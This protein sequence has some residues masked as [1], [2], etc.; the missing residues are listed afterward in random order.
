MAIVFDEKNNK[1]QGIGLYDPD[2]PIR[3]KMLSI[4]NGTKIDKSWLS[5][6]IAIAYAKRQQLL[7]SDVN[8]YRLL[9]G[10]N[11]GFPSLICDVYAQIAVIKIYSR[12]WLPFLEDIKEA[13]V[14]TTECKTMVLRL[15][16]NVQKLSLPEGIEEGAIIYG[17]LSTPE[18]IFTE[19]DVQ[20]SVNVIKGHKTGFFLD[21]RDNRHQI[22]KMAKGKKVLDVFSYAG[23][24]AIHAL[25]GGATNV[26][27]V[28][29][30]KHA[31]SVAQDNAKLN[32][33]T[34]ETINGDA[35]AILT[36]MVAQNERFDIII[37]DPPAFAKAQSE[38]EKALHHY[39]RLATL[40]IKLIKKD[41]TLLLASC[42][43]RITTDDFF[44]TVGAGMDSTGM[45]YEQ[46]RKAFHDI[47]HPIS[48]SEG[49]YLKCGYYKRL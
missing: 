21:H 27:A 39:R 43:S 4:E 32:G 11:D 12:I 46:T 48:F 49:A 34:L 13:I 10:E 16:R 22:Q 20:F 19:Y 17:T 18:I 40:G 38:I 14:A 1:F 5:E 25:K 33:V 9:F 8:G 24:F 37:I 29:I 42:S 44:E 26:T 41:G 47:D 3:I 30:S 2:S 36:K 7:E 15:S 35:F 6:R 45:P 23:G 31:L 28:D